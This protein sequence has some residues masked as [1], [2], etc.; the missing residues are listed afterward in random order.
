MRST[1]KH[2]SAR[3]LLATTLAFGAYVAPVIVPLSVATLAVTQTSCNESDLDKMV[4]V[5]R[6]LAGDVVTGEK[7]VAAVFAGG[8]ITLQQK[9]ALARRFKSIATAGSAYNALLTDLVAQAKNGTLP[10]SALQV[11]SAE[12]D[13]VVTP[14][15]ALLDDFGK[16]SANA[17]AAISLGIVALKAGV[18]AIAAIMASRGSK[19]AKEN[20]RNLELRGVYA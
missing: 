6:E 13:K 12:F 7:T 16:L 5:S 10:T 11:L 3:A 15:L 8:L 1:L 9:D 18:V 14:F 19:T 2:F 20:V 17:S 4:K